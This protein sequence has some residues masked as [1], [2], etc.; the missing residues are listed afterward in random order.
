MLSSENNLPI[1]SEILTC[2]WYGGIRIGYFFTDSGC[3]LINDPPT[4]DTLE[5]N[6]FLKYG[7]EK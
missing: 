6:K 5:S 2:S 7:E 1:R 4:P 3:A